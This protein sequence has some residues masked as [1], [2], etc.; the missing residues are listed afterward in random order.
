MPLA[1]PL[2]S[3]VIRIGIFTMKKF[4]IGSLIFLQSS[5]AFSIG[6]PVTNSEQLR[7]CWKRVVYEK[8]VM[9]Q[10]S[11]TDFYDPE[12]QKYQWYCFFD[13]NVFRVVTSNKDREYTTEQIKKLFEAAPS[14]MSWKWVQDSVVWVGHKDDPSMNSHWIV[15]YIDQDMY[16]FGKNLIPKGAL[17]MAIPT[18]DLKNFVI[19]R[20]LEKVK[21]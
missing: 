15:R 7:G 18:E 20:V 6:K 5:L 3:N 11:K 4:L 19:I 14:A 1:T 17:F 8:S 10:M 2:M 16:V 21:D 9:D 12:L 13:Q